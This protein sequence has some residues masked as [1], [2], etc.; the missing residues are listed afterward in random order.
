LI[1]DYD[2]DQSALME[3]KGEHVMHHRLQSSL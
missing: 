1:L 3:F 2:G